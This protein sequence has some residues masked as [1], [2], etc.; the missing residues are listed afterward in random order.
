MPGSVYYKTLGTKGVDFDIARAGWCA[1]YFDPFDY[2]NVLLDG[3]SIQDANNVNFAYFNNPSLN[4]AMDKA[5]RSVRCRSG[6]GVPAARPA[7]HEEPR[8]VG[9][10]TASSTRVFFIV[11]RVTN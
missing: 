4:A 3:R 11:A 10:R 7:H 8:S 5:A 6:E 2:I 1:D 9:A